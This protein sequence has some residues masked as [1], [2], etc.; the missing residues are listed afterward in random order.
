MSR[1]VIETKGLSSLIR[2]M[3]GYTEELNKRI[4]RSINRNGNATTAEARANH[5]YKRKGGALDRSI[6]FEQD[7]KGN[8]H[9]ADIFLD[10]SITSVDNG[11]SYGVFQHEGT[12]Q[13]YEQ[14]PIA[15]KY[16]SSAGK[17]GIKADPFLYNAI[18]KKFNIN[19]SLRGIAK[20]LQKRYERK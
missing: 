11:R 15:K 14:S 7:R 6:K 9:T 4:S 10:D 8:T 5:N 3:D 17:G 1:V 2:D 18:K 20:Q 12:H 16:S 13:G 19:K